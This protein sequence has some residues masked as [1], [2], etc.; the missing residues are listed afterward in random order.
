MRLCIVSK[1]L[2][3]VFLL[4]LLAACGGGDSGGGTPPLPPA[5]LEPG[6]LGDGRMTEI[7]EAIRMRYDLPAF[8]AVIVA[9]GQVADLGAS[10]LRTVTRE[11]AVTNSDQWHIASLTKAMTA[12]LAAILV[13]QSVISWDTTPLDIWPENAATMHPQYHSVTVV[14]L[15]AHQSGLGV[16]IDGVSS[17][18]W[19][20]DSAIGLV[21]EK[22][23]TWANELLQFPPVNARGEYLHTKAG[24]IV[25]GAMLEAVAGSSW[26]TQ[27]MEQLFGP[28]GMT[29]V[30]FGAP[31]NFREFDQPLGHLWEDGE[32]I[33]AHPGQI[34]DNPRAMGPAGT[35]HT[36][37]SDYAKFMFAH[38]E[39]ERGIPGIL[40]VDSFRFLHTPV[41]DSSYALGWDT[42]SSQAWGAGPVFSH[43]GSNLRWWA[44]VELA[45]ELNAGILTVT[46]AAND[47]AQNGS[48]EL[49]RI[50]V[51]RTLNSL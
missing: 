47:A 7:V 29:G 10:G 20:A 8:A 11:V 48:A 37:L 15:L 32:L 21:T 2:P 1:V 31:G 45:P 27:M 38:L 14:D 12:T 33:P 35:L 4:A 3:A 39:G 28:L 50:L 13:E 26:E 42:G 49:G 51:Q 5:A 46:N 16:E 43:S 18:D 22:R 30:G 24:Y 9:N 6:T 23:R 44:V 41:R 19:M 17:I 25:V 40:T 36:T 34:A